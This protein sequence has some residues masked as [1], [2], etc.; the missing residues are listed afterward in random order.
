MLKKSKVSFKLIGQ[1]KGEKIQFTS[2]VKSII[3][4]RVDKAQKTWLNSLKD[5]VLHG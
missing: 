1:F 5:L 2:G 3:D 4:L